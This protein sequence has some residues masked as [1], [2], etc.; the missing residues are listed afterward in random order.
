M[1]GELQYINIYNFPTLSEDKKEKEKGN[2][3]ISNELLY[4]VVSNPF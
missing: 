1:I 2:T 3:W 4:I